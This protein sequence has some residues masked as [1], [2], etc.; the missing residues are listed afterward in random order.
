META[1]LYDPVARMRAKAAQLREELRAAQAQTPQQLE[2]SQRTAKHADALSELERRQASYIRREDRLRAQLAAAANQQQQH[3]ADTAHAGGPQSPAEAASGA[4]SGGG[5]GGGCDASDGSGTGLAAMQQE[6]ISGVEELL[7]RQRLALRSD[8]AV[9][10]RHAKARL[11]E[12]EGR[13]RAEREEREQ[14]RDEGGASLADMRAELERT[15]AIAEKL[16]AVCEL[17]TA[18]AARLR[19][20]CGAQ[21]D[22]RQHLIR[23]MMLLKRDKWQ[24]GR[25]LAALQKEMDALVDAAACAVEERDSRR[26]DGAAAAHD[27]AT[28]EQQQ[29]QQQQQQQPAAA[30]NVLAAQEQLLLAVLAKCSPELAPFDADTGGYGPVAAAGFEPGFEPA[31]ADSAAANH[32]GSDTAIAADSARSWRPSE[33]GSSGCDGSTQPLES[34]SSRADSSSKQWQAP[35]PVGDGLAAEVPPIASGAFP[36]RW[37]LGAFAGGGRGRQQRVSG[38]PATAQAVLRSA[39]QS[40]LLSGGPKAAAAAAAG[41]RPRT[42]V[43]E[44]RGR[45]TMPEAASRRGGGGL[46]PQQAR[47]WIVDVNS[48]L[49]G[50][51]SGSNR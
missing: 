37:P 50:F 49:E 33:S 6:V 14:E 45:P 24:L 38:R 48:Q 28:H 20:E 25:E 12:L 7:E 30:A 46:H 32:H 40:R 51:L 13:L 22:D 31:M 43:L 8:E 5:G 2:G 1:P 29:Q 39:P 36:S 26:A 47:P 35:W 34:G 3:N 27:K 15:R 21:E 10:L 17:A 9:Q 18:E 19:V 16:D 42:A 44:G 4:S 23:Q 41:I 11:A